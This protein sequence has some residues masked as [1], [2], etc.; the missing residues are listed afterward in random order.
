MGSAFS[1]RAHSMA[2]SKVAMELVLPNLVFTS[3]S[4]SEPLVRC[5]LKPFVGLYSNFARSPL[6]IVH[7]GNDRQYLVHFVVPFLVTKTKSHW[8]LSKG[9]TKL[10]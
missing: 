10:M 7:F 6:L 8:G 4:T 5:F 1:D 3:I 2:G 9:L